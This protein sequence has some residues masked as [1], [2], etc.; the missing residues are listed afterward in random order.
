MAMLSSTA[1]HRLIGCETEGV[2]TYDQWQAWAIGLLLTP[3]VSIGSLM[4]Y[5]G[6]SSWT[7]YFA[8]AAGLLKLRRTEPDL[9]RRYRAPWISCLCCMSASV[10]L[11]GATAVA[12]PW[13]TLAAGM[14]ICSSWP[15]RRIRKRYLKHPRGV[16]PTLHNT[17]A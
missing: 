8:S 12:Q 2:G 4:S 7:F 1:G 13:P 16:P 6:V 5:F 3:G 17:Q 10:L 14:F 9:P 15:L 11:V